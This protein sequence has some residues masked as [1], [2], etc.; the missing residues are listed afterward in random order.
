ME[1]RSD[2]QTTIHHP[3]LCS[4][5]APTASRWSLPCG[6][7]TEVVQSYF[8]CSFIVKKRLN[9]INRGWLWK[10]IEAGLCLLLVC[11]YRLSKEKVNEK[12]QRDA[13][14]LGYTRPVSTRYLR[15]STLEGRLRRQALLEVMMMYGEFGES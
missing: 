13:I 3:A 9:I 6:S 10:K 14:G 2:F 8:S 1:A 7:L 15:G 5:A 4:H 12:K 11:Y